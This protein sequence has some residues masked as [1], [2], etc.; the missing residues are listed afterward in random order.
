MLLSSFALSAPGET[1]TG[2]TIWTSMSQLDGT[3]LWRSDSSTSPKDSDDATRNCTIGY[4][5]A[6]GEKELFVP[7]LTLPALENDSYVTTVADGVLK[8]TTQKAGKMVL[9]LNLRNFLPI[10]LTK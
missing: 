4:M 10:A 8:I 7:V 5:T 2:K 1:S 9:N 6:D 3:I